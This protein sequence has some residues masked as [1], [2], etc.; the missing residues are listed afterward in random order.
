MPFG[1]GFFATAGAGGAA[2]SFDLLETQILGSDTASVTFSSLDTNYAS[3][4]KHLQIRV[5][6]RTNRSSYSDPIYLAINGSTSSEYHSHGLWGN[7]S[8]VT[9][10]ASGTTGF[11]SVDY[12]F[13]ATAGSNL[14]SAHVYDFLDAFTANKNRTLRILTGGAGPTSGNHVELRSI[15]RFNTAVTSSIRLQPIGSFITGS[16]FSLYG[17]KAS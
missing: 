14:Y 1:L 10:G 16:R 2:G 15:A 8:S 5:T 3:T 12:A 9:S 6:A 4:Y 11:P 7:G 17:I 13:A